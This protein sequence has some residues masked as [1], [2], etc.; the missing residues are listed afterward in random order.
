MFEAK[1]LEAGGSLCTIMPGCYGTRFLM[2]TTADGT[3]LG[4]YTKVMRDSIAADWAFGI[5]GAIENSVRKNF[6]HDLRTWP[7][8]STFDFEAYELPSEHMVLVLK[9]KLSG[10]PAGPGV[11]GPFPYS[12]HPSLPPRIEEIEL[13]QF[14][15]RDKFGLR[16]EDAAF[17]IPIK[18]SGK[19][20]AQ[21]D[22]ALFS[23]EEKMYWSRQIGYV[24]V[25]YKTYLQSLDEQE[26]RQPPNITYVASGTNARVNVNSADSSVN[27]ISAEASE[28]FD[29][30]RERLGQIEDEVKREEIATAIDNMESAYGSDNFQS[31]YKEFMAVLADHVTVFAPF[32]PALANQLG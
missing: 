21:A 24:I 8:L 27:V 3:N 26:P 5:T 20:S 13:W 16:E 15:L 11:P 31:R 12:D 9:D 2:R 10:I 7:L 30:L 32:L 29:R 28:V 17:V 25:A 6:P 23:T 22:Y 19:S 1:I 18:D 4:L 14:Y